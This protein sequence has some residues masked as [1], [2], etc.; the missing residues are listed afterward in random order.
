MAMVTNAGTCLQW[1]ERESP[2]IGRARAAAD[3]VIRDGHRAGVVVRSI[4][5]FARRSPA[6]RASLDLNVATVET[7]SLIRGEL[8]RGEV[9]VLTE[10]T[11]QLPLAVGDR[12][13]IQQVLLN[14]I[15]NAMER[16]SRANRKTAFS[17]SSSAAKTIWFR[18]VS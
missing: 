8:R 5:A 6:A 1:R 12:V 13:Q 4:H 15:V 7:L 11:R 2:D 16:C 17:R 14:L 18:S 3:H 10:L 9:E